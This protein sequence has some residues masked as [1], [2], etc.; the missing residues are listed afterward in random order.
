MI[1]TDCDVAMF[2][3]GTARKLISTASMTVDFVRNKTRIKFFFV[4][5][6]D[7]DDTHV[8]CNSSPLR[9]EIF[10]KVFP[11]RRDDA[12]IHPYSLEIVVVR[13]RRPKQHRI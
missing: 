10:A 9:H 3:F 7:V 5:K 2:T 1:P 8:D 12:L 4:S 11:P 6:W 13:Q